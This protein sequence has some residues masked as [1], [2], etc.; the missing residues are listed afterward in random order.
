MTLSRRGFL[1][2]TAATAGATLIGCTP[3][4]QRSV[5]STAMPPTITHGVQSGDVSDGT[6]Q[7]WARCSEPAHMLVEWSTTSAFATTTAVRGPLVGPDR[8]HTGLTAL[9]NLP[10]GQTIHY[11]VKFERE[12]DRGATEWTVG[13][14][15][16]PRA[17]KLRI[18]WTGDTCGQGY[19]RNPDWGGLKGYES[20]LNAKPDLFLHVGDLIYADNPI[21]PEQTTWDGRVWKNVSNER[22]ARVAQELE[23]FRARFAYNFE[24]S[25]VAAL[26]KNVACIAQWD[27]HE[28]HNNWFPG[29]ILEDDR[30]I[31]ENRASVL[32]AWA[33]QATR[34]WTPIG[35]AT[36][37][38]VI[39]YGPLLDIVVVDLRTFR[40]PN[41]ANT[42]QGEAMLGSA[43]A[44]WLVDAL[45][46][47]KAR[48]KI[49]ACDQPL[50]LVIGDGPNNSRQ[51]G[52]ANGVP[53]APS[54]REA[55][56]AGVLAALKQ[57]GVKNVVWLTA[58]VH[59]AAHHAFDP[60]N[61]SAVFDPFHEFVAGPIHA[62]TFGP[63]VLD[64]TFGPEAKFVWAP[65]PGQGNL[66]PWDGLQ[67]F[68]TIDVT[69]DHLHVELVGIDGKP[70]YAIDLT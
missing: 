4:G 45:E 7:V 52:Y 51:E 55:E 33:M 31:K 14:L 39:H 53:G 64:P 44:R 27:D 28:T 12:V 62:G 58:D 16:T 70:R 10:A 2:G 3:R 48:W 19:G 11:R 17:D 35:G 43:Q 65:P 23:D 15:Q 54:G 66:A 50:A 32:A 42:G 1:V 6:A 5:V 47:S 49:V 38:R 67:S 24:D 22:V 30:Y 36:V 37:N 40:T 18:A 59:Y 8:D 61:A 41:D 34:E 21:L 20:I 63:N 56:L 9:A 46:T 57:R 13:R 26:A 60:K 68:G 25:N 69:K 29:Q